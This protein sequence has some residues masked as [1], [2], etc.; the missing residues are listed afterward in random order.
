MKQ[1]SRKRGRERSAWNS[2]ALQPAREGGRFSHGWGSLGTRESLDARP[3]E[4]DVWP[5]EGAYCEYSEDSVGCDAGAFT[6]AH[7]HLGGTV[8]K[9]S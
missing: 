6:P 5:R 9:A 4:P 2:P 3:V 8:P 7:H 1:G